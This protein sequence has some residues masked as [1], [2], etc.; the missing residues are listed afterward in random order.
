MSNCVDVSVYV[1]MEICVC[2][3]LVVYVWC[4]CKNIYIEL[5]LTI[6]NVKTINVFSFC[7]RLDFL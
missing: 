3:C 6:Y 5:Y 1:C 7:F 2:V 4:L